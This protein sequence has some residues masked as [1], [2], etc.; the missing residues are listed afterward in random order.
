MSGIA[1][2]LEKRQPRE[3]SAWIDSERDFSHSP[4]ISISVKG[5]LWP[6]LPS[7]AGIPFSEQ[8]PHRGKAHLLADVSGYS[9]GQ[10]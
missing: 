7:M 5:W 6:M 3:T 10:G 1:E 2:L 8:M 9:P 4:V